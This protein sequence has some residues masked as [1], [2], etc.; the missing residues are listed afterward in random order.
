MMVLDYLPGE[1]ITSWQAI[2]SLALG[3]SPPS[4]NR[5]AG[6][7]RP[8][9]HSEGPQATRNLARPSFFGARF[10]ASLEMTG[11]RNVFPQPVVGAGGTWQPGVA[12]V[13]TVSVVLTAGFDVQVE[14]PTVGKAPTVATARK[15]ICE[16]SPQSGRNNVAPRLAPWATIFRSFGLHTAP[17]NR[18]R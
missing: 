12:G 4:S 18:T 10:L 5:G 8:G 11:F 15:F 9:C 16:A 13:A 7:D 3:Y 2:Q 17:A 1:A 6:K 14:K